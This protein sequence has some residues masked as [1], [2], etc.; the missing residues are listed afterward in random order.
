MSAAKRKA[1]PTKP[2]KRPGKTKARKQARKVAKKTTKNAR[3][4]PRPLKYKA[5]EEW[6]GS[7]CAGAGKR[8]EGCFVDD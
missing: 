5:E 8:M 1:K 3:A 7:D 4:A 6:F 2:T